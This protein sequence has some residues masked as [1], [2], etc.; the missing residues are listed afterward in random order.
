MPMSNEQS[1][2][3][4][5]GYAAAEY[6]RDGMRIG[7]G[8]GSTVAF[9]LEALAEK[10]AKEKISVIGFARHSKPKI[11]LKNLAFRFLL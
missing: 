5:V 10:M 2:K 3:Q 8:T 6:V 7:L 1:S 11:T 4:V 9:F